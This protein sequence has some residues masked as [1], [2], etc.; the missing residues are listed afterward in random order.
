[1]DVVDEP[2]EPSSYSANDEH[3]NIV[4]CTQIEEDSECSSESK[5]KEE[6]IPVFPVRSV[7]K[8]VMRNGGKQIKPVENVD[9][10]SQ[11]LSDQVN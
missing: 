2:Q 7:P 9:E 8:K 11:Q 4:V 5:E 3:A 6:D 1:M 10:N